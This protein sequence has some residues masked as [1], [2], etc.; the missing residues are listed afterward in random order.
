MLAVSATGTGQRAP[1]ERHSEAESDDLADHYA[2]AI[3]GSI[4][5][6]ALIE[7][8]RGEHAHA[9]T[10]ALSTLATMAV[11]WLAHVWSGIMGERMH[12][13]GP[14]G[15]D[16][17][18]RIARAEWPLVEASF[19]PIFVLALGWAGAISDNVAA[20]VALAVCV[21]QLFGWGLAV[22]LR[23]YDHWQSALFSGLVNGALG[24]V[25]VSLE[26]AVLH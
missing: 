21:I 20:E 25:V 23:A 13:R 7:A 12:S 5:A 2:A 14:V 11:F 19:A 1:G 17:A 6:A 3:Y 15:L 9:E 10:I 4:V 16:G 26:V 22:G 24:L 18:A 8:F